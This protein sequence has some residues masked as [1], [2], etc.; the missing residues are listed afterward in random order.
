MYTE[1]NEMVINKDKTK[2]MIFNEAKSLDFMPNMEVDN[3][4]FEVVEE[5]KLL[6]LVISSDLKWHQNTKNMCQKGFSRLWM[7]RRL[8]YLNADIFDLKDVYE[9]QVRSVLEFG[10]PVFTAGLTEVECKTIERVQ[11]TA[12]AIILGPQYTSYPEA[13]NILG[14]NTL[15]DRRASLCSNFAKKSLKHPKFTNWFEK[16]MED[17]NV[18]QTRSEKTLLKPVKTRTRRFRKSPVPYLTSL[19]NTITTK[20]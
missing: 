14:L 7:L 8:K 13:L 17:N 1:E 3:Q 5:M 6:G 4:K 2:V 20:K 18:R 10:V 9:K 12:L 19:V 11:K 15:K 16:N